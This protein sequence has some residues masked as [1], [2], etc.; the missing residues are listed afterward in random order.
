VDTLRREYAQLVG[1]NC[2]EA[3]TVVNGAPKLY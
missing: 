3:L 1:F 2:E